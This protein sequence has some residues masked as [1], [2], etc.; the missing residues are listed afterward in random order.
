M[1]AAIAIYRNDLRWWRSRDDFRLVFI[2]RRVAAAAEVVGST[3]LN[4]EAVIAPNDFSGIYWS[5]SRS[6]QGWGAARAGL[7][8]NL[9]DGSEPARNLRYKSCGSQANSRMKDRIACGKTKSIRRKPGE[10]R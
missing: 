10:N 3:K 2:Q 6:H 4:Q 7:S 5:K 9:G 8:G 1:A